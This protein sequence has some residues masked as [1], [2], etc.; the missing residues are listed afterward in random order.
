MQNKVEDQG[1]P[2]GVITP[3]S[4]QTAKNRGDEQTRALHHFF[5]AS[6]TL[7]R[8]ELRPLT[9]AQCSPIANSRRPDVKF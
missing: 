9:L 7:L 5:P 2:R 1:W 8:V 6:K 4:C 3:A